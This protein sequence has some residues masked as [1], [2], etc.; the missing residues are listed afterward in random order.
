MEGFLGFALI[1]GLFVAYAMQRRAQRRAADDAVAPKPA[2][3]ESSLPREP[4]GAAEPAPAAEQPVSYGS[5]NWGAPI[6]FTGLLIAAA[7][8]RGSWWG[9]LWQVLYFAVIAVAAYSTFSRKELREEQQRR[10]G[11]T[12]GEVY[13]R[14]GVPYLLVPVVAWVLAM[15]LGFGAAVILPAIPWILLALLGIGVAL[16][17]R[18]S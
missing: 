17:K 1:A 11:T 14:T 5:P 12:R 3:A 4:A 9:T 2:V 16:F 8:H 6:I 10:P 15:P 13:L 7:T 18:P